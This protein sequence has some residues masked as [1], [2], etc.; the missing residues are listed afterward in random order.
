MGEAELKGSSL[1][2]ER[3]LERACRV[4]G[5]AT[6][7]S[8]LHAVPDLK[9]LYVLLIDTQKERGRSWKI[10]M[11]QRTCYSNEDS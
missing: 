5:G 8:S 4:N 10:D 3:I 6:I 7:Q 11:L 1:K 2:L 9:L